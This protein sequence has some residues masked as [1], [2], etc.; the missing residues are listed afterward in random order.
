MANPNAAGAFGG[1]GGGRAGLNGPNYQV[2]K[3]QQQPACASVPS[4]TAGLA[5]TN[6][7]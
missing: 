5:M 6:S 2:P 1:G 4:V 7:I 3:L